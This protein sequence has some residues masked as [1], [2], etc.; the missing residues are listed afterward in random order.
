MFEDLQD[1]IGSHD[2][3]ILM[4]AV[5]ALVVILVAKG[6]RK[7]L[8]HHVSN[9]AAR[10]KIR[11][12]VS[13]VSLFVLLVLAGFIWIRQLGNLGLFVSIIG[14][15][16]ALS[17]QQGLLCMAGWAMILLKRP[18]DIGD[19]V[20]IEGRIGDVI[21]I[22]VFHTS[23]LEVGNWV[24]A[25]QST[26][27]LTIVPNSSFFRHATYN[28]TKGF[29]FIWHE[30]STIVTFESDWRAAKEIMLH[31][32]QEEAERTEKEVHAQIRDM[33]KHYA[34]RYERLTPIVY[35]DIADNGVRLTLRC[36]CQVRQRRDTSHRIA[37]GILSALIEHPKIDFAY[38]T[39]R[40]FQ[41]ST[42][43]KPALGR[44]DTQPPQT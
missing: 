36:L 21:D 26:G 8:L 31:Q 15:G 37:E 14:A 17:L 16:L 19:R 30:F 40:Y 29:P 39:T 10:H 33:Q 9:L 12:A 27:R 6:A 34:I 5:S 28:Y 13:W 38:P 32:A 1:W 35:T 23:L 20:E 42:E 24:H 43:G 18:F 4:T 25:D 7:A 22:D 41:N 44:P 3:Q 11:R 2:H